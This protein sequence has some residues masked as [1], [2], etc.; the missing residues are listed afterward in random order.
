MHEVT[1]KQVERHVGQRAMK[2]I[3]WYEVDDPVRRGNRIQ[4][5]VAGF[6]V[7]AKLDEPLTSRCSCLYRTACDHAAVLLMKWLADPD[8]FKLE[9]VERIELP[10]DPQ[11]LKDWLETEDPELLDE[12]LDELVQ[13]GHFL[14]RSHPLWRWMAEE[15]G[16]ALDGLAVETRQGRVDPAEALRPVL[17][18]LHERVARR[19]ARREAIARASSWRDRPPAEEALVELW[20]AASAAFAAEDRERVPGALGSVQLKPDTDEL[21][22]R[23]RSS[24]TMPLVLPVSV[25]LFDN[26][27]Q[28]FRSEVAGVVLDSVIGPM[29]PDVR[30]G[31]LRVLQTPT[32]QRALARLDAALSLEGPS[33]DDSVGWKI[34][35]Q[36]G[37]IEKITPVR[38]TP[39]KTRPGFRTRALPSHE[40]SDLPLPSDRAAHAALKS[41]LPPA[42][43]LEHLVDHPR[44][45]GED[46]ELVRVRRS[47]LEVAVRERDGL[48][49]EILLDGEAVPAPLLGALRPSQGLATVRIGG[50]VAVVAMGP[51]M[52]GLTD[53][54]H[55]YGSDFPRAARRP[56]MLRLGLL[57]QSVP[58]RLDGEMRGVQVHADLRPVFVLIPL[59]DGALR[60]EVRLRPLPDGPPYRPG[61]GPAEVARVVRG[62]RTFAERDLRREPARVITQLERLPLPLLHDWDGTIDDPDDAL[63]L[64]H[65]LRAR[66][67]L[68]VEWPDRSL[69]VAN[70]AG[71]ATRL[72]VAVNRYRDWFG[73]EGELQVGGTRVSLT[74][75]LRAIRDQRRYVRLD[76]HGW[77]QLT[78]GL[79]DALRTAAGIA[80]LDEGPPQLP[81]LAM[82]RAVLELERAGAQVE[83][84][85]ELQDHQALIRAADALHPEVPAGL[86]AE[87]RPYQLEGVTWLR[88]MACWAPGAVLADDMGLGKTLQALAFVLGRQEKPALVVA[89]ASVNLNWVRETGRFAPDLRVA[90]YRGAGRESLLEAPKGLLVTSYDLL[91]RDQAILAEVP[92]GTVIF[93]E[94]QAL[95]NPLSKRAR[96]ARALD[97]DFAL[98]LSGTP[99][100][101]DL[102][103]LWSLM[104]C[105]APGLLGP[106][107]HFLQR[108]GTTG[109]R[110]DPYAHGQLGRLVRPFILRR[111]KAA[112]A[113]E[114]PPREESID[115]IELTGPERVVYERIR[116]AAVGA[117]KGQKEPNRIEVLA[118]LTRLRQAACA[119][120]LVEPEV[121]GDSAKI[122]RLVE[123]VQEVRE[124]GAQALVFSQFTSLLDL[125]QEALLARGVRILR[126][127]GS[128]PVNRRQALVDDFQR[129]EADVF[130]ISLKAGGTGL[131][132]T[133]ATTVIH[134]DPW[135]NPAAEDQASDRAHRIGQT[136]QVYV[137]RLVAAGTV[138]EQVLAL[139]EEK[140]ALASM[141]L[142]GTSET[143]RMR[144]EDL[145][146][147]LEG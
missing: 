114:L 43:V 129:G 101:N 37:R 5:R 54:L 32:W 71:E 123:R 112:V 147:I 83:A 90:L 124:N 39:F 126:L 27:G 64:V 70:G 12:T 36:E 53:V 35:D 1:E 13:R 144:S 19:R 127:D 100:E 121:Q 3:R 125:A 79:Q 135:W 81:A 139:H 15:L 107:E 86:R 57:E 132:L 22:F 128:T 33:A 146:A 62:E 134:L 88:R 50:I 85:E 91:V 24:A 75:L 45:V 67:D 51:V 87:L 8:V 113:P 98:A 16:N 122:A 104:R 103:E 41:S 46:G 78:V 96:A 49:V 6:L 108:F 74:E 89:P 131:N 59:S 17:G 42:L 106:R 95:K 66:P 111:T 117:L 119:A 76:D 2:R 116:Q 140:R 133:A 136:E 52:D 72:R 130:L 58:L 9:E 23:L 38:L 47:Q 26:L 93:D 65:A 141:V 11:D 69:R 94:A 73:V 63:D 29:A 44:V 40:L 143:H 109:T 118:A 34:T 142:E 48:S 110:G 30:E 60:V 68:V 21:V 10:T 55:R 115:W 4:G 92:F 82:A 14:P 145:L 137:I 120:R 77:L 56:L 31:V 99:V 25:R 97:V 20:E 61:A 7:S 105:V 102:V 28:F 138:E 80:A 84:P 18:E